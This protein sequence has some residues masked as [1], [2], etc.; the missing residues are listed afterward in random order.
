[1]IGAAGDRIDGL[2]A[3]GRVMADEGGGLPVDERSLG[4]LARL[5]REV[6]HLEPEVRNE[7]ADVID[8]LEA[9]L[10]GELSAEEAERVRG[11]VRHVVEAIRR[12]HDENPVEA[13]RERFEETVGR[14]AAEAP[15]ASGVARRLIDLLADLGI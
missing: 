9:A 7:L 6:D 15:V 3:E 8:E 4:E 10:R 2:E 1:M 5:L 12:Q 11:D 14:T 13:A